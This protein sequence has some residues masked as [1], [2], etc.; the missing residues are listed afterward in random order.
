VRRSAPIAASLLAAALL[1]T[2]CSGSGTHTQ[3]P[4]PTSPTGE[5]ST[6]P[7]STSS[8]TAPSSPHTTPTRKDQ[9]PTPTVTP[10]SQAAVDAYISAYNRGNQLF[11]NPLAANASALAEFE[12]GEALQ[13]DTTSL[14]AAARAGI[15]YRGTP[16]QPRIKV[17][18]ASVTV[19]A[20]ADC[21]L[22]SKTDPY[23]E[24]YVKTG[25]AVPQRKLP[26]PPP[27]L[28]AITVRNTSNGWKV[29]DIAVDGSK[30]CTP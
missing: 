2:A 19:V 20:I 23:V 24:Y 16:A 18:T 26:H 5:P 27:Y 11:L 22:E 30:T 12:M 29:S 17:V 8:A 13:A 14:K 15:A 10:P 4:G 1:A 25:A 7:T 28:H 21:G 3:T 6:T 9:V